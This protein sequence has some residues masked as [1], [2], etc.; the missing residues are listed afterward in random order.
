MLGQSL[1]ECLICWRYLQDFSILNE[2]I[3]LLGLFADGEPV[4]PSHALLRGMSPAHRLK[5]IELF[6]LVIT[7]HSE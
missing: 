7:F 6:H 4:S 2:E 5:S 1:L 3:G